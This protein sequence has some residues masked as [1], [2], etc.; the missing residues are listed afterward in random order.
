MTV[1]PKPQFQCNLKKNFLPRLRRLVF[2]ILF[3]PSDGPPHEGGG[4]VAR[5]VRLEGGGGSIPYSTAQTV[6][7]HLERCQQ[8]YRQA[9]Q[10]KM[11]RKP[12]PDTNT[13]N[14]PTGHMQ[15]LVLRAHTHKHTNTQTR[16]HTHDRRDKQALLQRR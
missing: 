13:R 1:P 5:G 7:V 14:T 3:G 9:L 11:Q 15:R 12:G 6:S 8:S 10:G 16:T 4:G 2:P